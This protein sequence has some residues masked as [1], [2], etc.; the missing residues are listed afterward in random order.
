RVTGERRHAELHN[1][2]VV[3]LALPL[4]AGSG[5]ESLEQFGRGRSVHLQH[6]S[7]S[8]NSIRF[9][10]CGL[11]PRAGAPRVSVRAYV[12]S[13]GRGTSVSA[14]RPHPYTGPPDR[15][16]LPTPRGRRTAQFDLP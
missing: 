12:V 7:S 5:R 2:G 13:G 11:I 8:A 1:I 9:S 16:T 3:G 10:V 6:P 4:G 15:T 14:L